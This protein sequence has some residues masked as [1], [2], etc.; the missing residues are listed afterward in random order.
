M[1]HNSTTSTPSSPTPSHGH[2]SPTMTSSSITTT[3]SQSSPR[4][5]NLE[6]EERKLQLSQSYLNFWL[7]AEDFALIPAGNEE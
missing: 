4:G 7:D 5:G 6:E 3:S 2:L 1:N